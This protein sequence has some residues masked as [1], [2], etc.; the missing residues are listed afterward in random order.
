[1]EIS[2][3]TFDFEAVIKMNEKQFIVSV[4]SEQV[5]QARDVLRKM[6]ELW[7]GYEILSLSVGTVRPEKSHMYPVELEDDKKEQDQD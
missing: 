1:M 5:I 2:A 3:K 6:K 4:K 7:V